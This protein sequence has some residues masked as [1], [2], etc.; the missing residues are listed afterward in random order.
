MVVLLVKD[1]LARALLTLRLLRNR[2]VSFFIFLHQFYF[3]ILYYIILFYLTLC[4]FQVFMCEE[5]DSL[6]NVM[7][8]LSALDFKL[9]KATGA[10]EV[11]V[12][13]SSFS[14]LFISFLFH[15]IFLFWFLSLFS[16]KVIS[17][18]I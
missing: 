2:F 18:I 10:P 9:V 3:I 7:I 4:Y 17:G 11:T 1:G 5:E 15:F 8:Q 12:S 16:S 13:I 14:I 6:V